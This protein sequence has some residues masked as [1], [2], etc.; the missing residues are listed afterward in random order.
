MTFLV[1]NDFQVS[2]QIYEWVPCCRQLIRQSDQVEKLMGSPIL[3]FSR[4]SLPPVQNM[5]RMPKKLRNVE[6]PT[7]SKHRDPRVP[8]RRGFLII[9]DA[10]HAQPAKRQMRKLLEDRPCPVNSSVCC[11]DEKSTRY[12]LRRTGFTLI[13]PRRPVA[14]FGGG[15]M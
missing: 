5:P 7:F 14:A 6:P 11:A 3:P 8:C 4:F 9:G 12:R 2:A 13:V 1:S 10:L 15:H